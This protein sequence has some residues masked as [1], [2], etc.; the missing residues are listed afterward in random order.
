MIKDK[1]NIKNFTTIPFFPHFVGLEN[2][3]FIN[4]KPLPLSL[5]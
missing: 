1:K 2:I 5:F 3:F 4:E